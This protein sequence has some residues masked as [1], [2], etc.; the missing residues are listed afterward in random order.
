MRQVH[1]TGGGAHIVTVDKGEGRRGWEGQRGCGCPREGG[2]RAC[3]DKRAL[4][5]ELQA[6][7]GPIGYQGQGGRYKGG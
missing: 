4:G 5:E 1:T 7:A 6:D 2:A 3:G